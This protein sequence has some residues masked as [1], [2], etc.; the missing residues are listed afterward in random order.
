MRS[1]LIGILVVVAG[2][3]NLQAQQAAQS[4]KVSYDGQKVA[5]VELVANPKISTESLKPLAQQK[6]GQ[7]Y[8]SAKVNATINALKSTNRFSKVELLVKPGDGGLRLTFT[9]EPALYFGILEF[10]GAKRFTYTRLLQVVDVPDQTP[11]QQQLVDQAQD[12]LKQFFIETGF[13]QAQVRP[14]SRFDEAHM[15]ANVIFHIDLG[16][17]AKIGQVEIQGADPREAS[18]LTQSTRSLCARLRRS[19]L[20]PGQPYTSKRIDA[21]VALIKRELIG[22]R[23]LASKVR[24]DHA[25]YHAD[26]NRADVVINAQP[27]PIVKI[28]IQGAKLSDIPF[29]RNR[30]MKRLIPIY[31]EGS[32]DP[33]LVEE[34][35][36]NLIDFFQSKGYFDT[37]V[38]TDFH[39]NPSQVDLIYHVDK[40]RSHLVEGVA[41]RGNTH[42]D[43]DDL[44]PQVLVQK[45]TALVPRMFSHGKFS[46]KLVRKSVNA[47]TAFYKDHG[48]EDVKVEP[49]VVDHEP[50][51]YVTFLITEGPQRQSPH[52]VVGAFPS[53]RFRTSSRATV[54]SE[55]TDQRPRSHPCPI[56]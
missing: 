33:D 47:I 39:E 41:F 30:R 27:G 28:G 40:G 15:L 23:R 1:W 26:T 8:S 44:M 43:A 22:Q 34:G 29:L 48:Y 53:A 20:K 55:G 24:F 21:A 17:R 10:P 31:T 16:R 25:N 5:A 42:F 50:R 4:P 38:T 45:H 13:F 56:S 3:S 51:I 49:D 52:V 2:L 18:Y 37:K 32:V 12:A 7:P 9:L 6:A 54:L 35:R 19:S 46:N 14:E 11:F 36:E